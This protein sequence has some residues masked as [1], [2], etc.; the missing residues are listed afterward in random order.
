MSLS[1][2][3]LPSTLR[4]LAA[5][6]ASGAR[7]PLILDPSEIATLAPQALQALAAGTYTQPA[8][9]LGI[10]AGATQTQ[11]GATQLA[12]EINR[13]DTNATAGN[14]VALPS[15]LGAG[16][17][18]RCAVWNNTALALRVYPAVADAGATINGVAAATGILLTPNSIEVFWNAGSAAWAVDAGM[19]FAGQLPTE[20]PQ[21]AIT[22]HA[23]GGQANATVLAADIN[24]VGVVAS[25]ND[26]LQLPPS[27]AGLSLVVAVSPLVAN[28]CALYSNWNGGAP[29]DTIDGLAASA[30]LTL[31]PGSVTIFV[32]TASGAW[33][34]NGAGQGFY[35]S[36]LTGWS[37]NALTATGT[38]QAT[39]LALPAQTNRF[40]TVA[41]GTG[42]TLSPTTTA[43][44]APYAL[45]ANASVTQTIY[46][47][48]ANAL[49][50][51]P[52]A[53]G[54]ETINA[55]AANAGFS[56][57]AGKYL[58]CTAFAPGVWHTI[59]SA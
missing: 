59:L 33:R 13:V 40:G 32:C 1:A 31:M 43:A 34:S 46:N 57:P 20:L 11:A 35:G 9:A 8:A 42:C 36:L 3:D 14:G 38:N 50:V 49:L 2:D 37:V 51:Y 6:P 30:A 55:L 52:A 7:I 39:A 19:G 56:L 4:A 21:D 15:A 53:G 45:P 41:A 22:A 29:A 26:S 27:A 54:T 17:A 58:Q 16:G 48:G 47:A 28:Q 12:A 24:G 10:T 23:G 5:L 44:G 25:A 18:R